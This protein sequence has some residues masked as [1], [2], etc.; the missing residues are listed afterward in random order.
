M[1]ED[2]PENMKESAAALSEY[3]SVVF[4][5]TVPV[6]INLDKTGVFTG[7][8]LEFEKNDG[9][10]TG[11]FSEINR[12]SYWIPAIGAGSGAEINNVIGSDGYI[13]DRNNNLMRFLSTPFLYYNY[14]SKQKQGLKPAMEY[15]RQTN[16]H[17]SQDGDFVYN[18]YE[19]GA[20]ITSYVGN[21]TNVTIPNKLGGIPVTC[22]DAARSRILLL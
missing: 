9:I 22:K 12:N 19:S 14:Y 10:C 21:S 1:A 18:P 7:T 8:S 4:T 13:Y 17:V 11:N 16:A 6:S 5:E 2:T 3:L 20:V 15:I